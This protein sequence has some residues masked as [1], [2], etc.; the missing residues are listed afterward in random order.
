MNHIPAYNRS[1]T[2]HLTRLRRVNARL[3]GRIRHLTRDIFL[4]THDCDSV[5]ATASIGAAA[6]REHGRTSRELLNRADAAMYVE[7][8]Q[9]KSFAADTS[10]PSPEPCTVINATRGD[11]PRILIIDND[12][13]AANALASLVE[14]SGHGETRVACSGHEALAVAV[15]FVP[16]VV[17]LNLQLRDMSG[18]DVARQLSQHPRLQEL[19]LIALTGSGEHPGREQAREAGFERY[20]IEP[21]GRT[22]LAELFA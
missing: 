18:Y 8:L 20:L 11:M 14:T 1:A 2:T 22:E 13:G 6:Y 15:T 4:A 17:L 12:V 16:T 3:A 9:R 7:E 21:P 10:G 5:P 19:R